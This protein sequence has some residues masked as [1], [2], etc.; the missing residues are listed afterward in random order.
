[1]A[2]A[3]SLRKRRRLNVAACL[4]LWHA[5]VIYLLSSCQL[6]TPFFKCRDLLL[7]IICPNACEAVTLFVISNVRCL[8]NCAQRREPFASAG[9]NVAACMRLWYA[10]LIYLLSGCQLET[11]FFKCRNVLSPRQSP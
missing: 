2:A 8:K 9:P 3:Q 5:F 11:P 6:P 7:R 1:R 10:F 4:R